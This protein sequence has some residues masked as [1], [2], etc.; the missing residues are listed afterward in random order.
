MI[1]HNNDKRETYLALAD[2]YQL[3]P[4]SDPLHLVLVHLNQTHTYT[5]THV[6]TGKR[7]ITQCPVC[8]LESLQVIPTIQLLSQPYWTVPLLF[9]NYNE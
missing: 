1:E 9:W 7:K 3:L 4:S 8:K 5:H 6:I 2:L